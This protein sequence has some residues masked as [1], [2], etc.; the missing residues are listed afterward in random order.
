MGFEPGQRNAPKFFDKP[1][2]VAADQGAGSV[3]G[4]AVQFT[5]RK[6]ILPQDGHTGFVGKLPDPLK[7][8]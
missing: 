7:S 3:N 2:G 1:V 5:L 6:A 4:N 8:V